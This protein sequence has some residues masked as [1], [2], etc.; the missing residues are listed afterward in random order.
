[1][2]VDRK[3]HGLARLVPDGDADCWSARI[4][5]RRRKEPVDRS[6]P[7]GKKICVTAGSRDVRQRRFARPGRSWAQHLDIGYEIGSGQC[8]ALTGY[9]LRIG[10]AS[11]TSGAAAIDER[12]AFAGKGARFGL[13]HVRSRLQPLK[14]IAAVGIRYGK[15]AVFKHDPNARNALTGIA[16]NTFPSSN[17]TDERHPR[18]DGLAI[19]P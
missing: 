16:G 9:E 11:A 15:A 8:P 17:P 1:M 14:M 3:G 6:V 4:V 18:S 10:A 12:A 13:D 19:D 5:I 7:G 2:I